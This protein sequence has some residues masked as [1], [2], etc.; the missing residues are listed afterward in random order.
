MIK[1]Q[2]IVI[3]TAMIYP[4]LIK[5]LHNNAKLLIWGSDLVAEIDIM[6]TQDIIILPGQQSPVNTGI[7]LVAPLGTNARI[8]R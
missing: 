5:R 3:A 4:L 1:L 6:V 8:A 2:Q 7:A